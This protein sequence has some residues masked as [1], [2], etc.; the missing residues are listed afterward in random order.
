MELYNEWSTFSQRNSL[1]ISP[2]A[3]CVRTTFLFTVEKYSIVWICHIAI[4]V[5]LVGY[6]G[7]FYLLTF[8]S[9]STTTG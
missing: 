8:M 7:C 2:V 3:M 9:N 1:K 6:L 5:P 4:L